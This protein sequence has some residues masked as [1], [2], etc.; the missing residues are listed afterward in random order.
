MGAER[1]T[2]RANPRPPPDQTQTLVSKTGDRTVKD[3]PLPASE[4]HETTPPPPNRPSQRPTQRNPIYT[5]GFTE[6]T[7]DDEP[8]PTA[9]QPVPPPRFPGWIPFAAGAAV[10]VLAGLVGGLGIRRKPEPVKIVTHANDPATPSPDD[11]K[12]AREAAQKSA[13][14]KRLLAEAQNAGSWRQMQPL[15][16][17]VASLAPDNADAKALRKSEADKLSLQGAAALKKNHVDEAVPDFEG[18][19]ALTP[20]DDGAKKTLSR[21]LAFRALGLTEKRKWPAAIVDADRAVS[22]D[23]DNWRAHLARADIYGGQGKTS[24]AAEEYRKVLELKPDEKRARK[25]LAATAAP[26][27]KPKKK[28]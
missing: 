25:A 8:A 10:L 19:L 22:L 17:Q 16:D 11:E 2:A 27:K 20:D 15:L 18:A 26:T 23:P 3:Q 28:R 1:E 5:G 7:R 21:V 6:A 14:V 4:N 9:I 13:E 12:K 24:A